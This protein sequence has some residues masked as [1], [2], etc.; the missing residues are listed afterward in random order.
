MKKSFADRIESLR[1]NKTQKEFAKQL[2]Q[3]EGDVEK[4]LADVRANSKA[5][6]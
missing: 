5:P 3:A 4:L 1:G 6:A 2:G